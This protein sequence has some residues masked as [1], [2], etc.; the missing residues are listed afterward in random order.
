MS[1]NTND[2]NC[3]RTL[4]KDFI[5][6][7]KYNLSDTQTM[8]VSYL[9]LLPNWAMER[10]DGYFV[11]LTSKIENDLKWGIKTIEATL[12]VLKKLGLIET[13][14]VKVPLWDTDKNFRAI[15]LTEKGQEYNL[16]YLKPRE[17]KIVRDAEASSKSQEDEINELKKRL[18]EEIAK[19]SKEVKD[20]E[21]VKTF[22]RNILLPFLDKEIL[23]NSG[24]VFLVNKIISAL[25]GVKIRLQ[26]RDQLSLTIATR[27]K[28]EVL[29][30]KLAE[31]W[32]IERREAYLVK[33]FN[34]EFVKIVSFLHFIVLFKNKDYNFKGIEEA[35]D[36]KVLLKLELN[37][38]TE[39]SENTPRNVELKY[40]TYT[41]LKFLRKN[42]SNRIF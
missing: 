26:H 8:F 37:D 4:V 24:D 12:N 14:L 41:A 18:K 15:R 22:N 13:M 35:E 27:G 7:R 42:R 28:S 25:D 9:T 30:P 29:D 20:T 39:E 40:D 33:H 5:F 10:G 2:T 3:T 19:N 21:I 1:D 31:K 6:Q 17:L 11:L 38:P 32:L 16:A 23:G 34:D 36:Y